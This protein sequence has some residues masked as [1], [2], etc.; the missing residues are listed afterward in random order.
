MTAK[1]LVTWVPLNSY[2]YVASPSSPSRPYW[3]WLNLLSLDAPLI[4]VLWMNL[5]AAAFHAP[6]AADVSLTLGLVVWMVYV[7][8]RIVDGS[9]S[10]PFAQTAR[11]HFHRRH[12]TSLVVAIVAGLG[13][14]FYACSQL[15]VR[16]FRAGLILSFVVAVYLIA[17]HVLHLHLPKEAVVA[18]LFGAGTTFPVAIRIEHAAGMMIGAA[19]LF[20][21]LCWLNLVLIEYS[22]WQALSDG[23]SHL[24]RPTTMMAGRHFAWLAAGV[25]FL[26]A[27]FCALEAGQTESALFVAI[28]L[29]AAAL[30]VLSGSRRRFSAELVRVLADAALLTP[31]VVLP[32]LIK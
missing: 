32:F 15:D 29:A 10:N 17:V 22:E 23:G 8:D 12:R 2:V 19:G 4:A 31:A 5:F 26:S 14:A 7:A 27:S 9:T 3:L 16:T 25:A 1:L 18:V 11:H 28:S 13:V 21:V 30:G 20:G 24:L 6:L